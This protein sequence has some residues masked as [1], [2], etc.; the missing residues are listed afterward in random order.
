MFT[1]VVSTLAGIAGITWFGFYL[2]DR[3]HRRRGE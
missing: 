3:F 2:Y 1:E